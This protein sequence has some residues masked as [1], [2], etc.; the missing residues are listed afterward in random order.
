MV[1]GLTPHGRPD[2]HRHVPLAV[3]ERVSL[4]AVV[5][6]IADIMEAG[7]R[8]G[9]VDR[10]FA[11]RIGSQIHLAVAQA[12]GTGRISSGAELVGQQAFRNILS[13]HLAGT[14]SSYTD[15]QARQN[16]LDFMRRH[17]NRTG[18]DFANFVAQFRR[19]GG[20]ADRAERD[21]GSLLTSARFDAFSAADAALLARMRD[22][23]TRHGLHWAADRPEILRMGEEAIRLLARTGF[24]RESH[25]RLHEA[26]FN[27]HQMVAIAR[28]AERTG[29]DVNT[30]AGIAADSVRIFGEN[31]EAERRRWRD[32]IDAYHRAPDN[33]EARDG[34]RTEL[35]RMRPE[36]T[37]EQQGQAGTHLNLMS[38]ADQALNTANT[39]TLRAD[40]ADAQVDAIA[41][42]LNGPPSAPGGQLPPTPPPQPT[43]HVAA[44][45]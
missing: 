4:T 19:G 41:D 18:A 8:G 28:Y 37:P 11:G 25:D 27:H 12:L 21:A 15:Q 31:D 40:T 17:A 26:G 16:L 2:R 34:L 10:V 13:Q 6:A 24:T 20:Y 30:V 14:S 35:E 29:Q 22:F 36:G 44:P 42:D 1:L 3:H 9:V 33:A 5:E 43:R 45:R 7:N 38:Q 39:T 32:M 23:A